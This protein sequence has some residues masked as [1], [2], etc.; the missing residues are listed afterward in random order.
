MHLSLLSDA[1]LSDSLD[2]AGAALV[3]ASRLGRETL[4]RGATVSSCFPS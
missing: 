1:Y 2:D 3:P 4:L